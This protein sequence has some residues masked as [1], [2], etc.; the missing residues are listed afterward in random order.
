MA[1]SSSNTKLSINR[2]GELMGIN[3]YVLNGV[4]VGSCIDAKVPYD[5]EQVWTQYRWQSAANATREQLGLAIKAST[6]DIEW[7]LGYPVAPTYFRSENVILKHAEAKA[8]AKTNTVLFYLDNKK[9]ISAGREP[10]EPTVFASEIAGYDSTGDGFDDM[11]MIK[12]YLGTTDSFADTYKLDRPNDYYGTLMDTRNGVDADFKEDYFVMPEP[13]MADI[14]YVPDVID[15]LITL[16]YVRFWFPIQDVVDWQHISKYP[17]QAGYVPPD[18]CSTDVHQ[19]FLLH[20]KASSGETQDAPFVRIYCREDPTCT[21]NCAETIHP[22]VLEVID[23]EAGLV[24]VTLATPV[25]EEIAEGQEVFVGFECATTSVDCLPYKVEID[26]RAGVYSKDGKVFMEQEIAKMAAAR[27]PMPICECGNYGV[28]NNYR[29]DY[30]VYDKSAPRRATAKLLDNPFGTRRG[31]VEAW[32][33][34]QKHI[35]DAQ[36]AGLI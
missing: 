13:S 1:Y 35:G 2:W 9:I 27:L 24:A 21:T 19:L 28:A 15:P 5:C 14:E 36:Y 33:S 17:G 8:L 31:E 6:E 11:T 18:I 23:S 16:I 7:K 29:D 25:M 3:P 4:Q 22:G 32:M 26:Y 10:D 12:F 34:I 20:E 30:A